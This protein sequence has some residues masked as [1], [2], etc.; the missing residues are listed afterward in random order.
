MTA[1]GPEPPS[2]PESG[3][4]HQLVRPFHHLS[5]CAQE[6]SENG[7]SIRQYVTLRKLPASLRP[8][9][10]EELEAKHAADPKALMTLFYAT[11][12]GPWPDL[13]ASLLSRVRASYP[14]DPRVLLGSFAL[15]AVRRDWRAL[16]EALDALDPTAL[17]SFGAFDL[18]HHH[19]LRATAHAALGYLDEARR[20]LALAEAIPGGGC[21]EPLKPLRAALDALVD[22]ITPDD[23]ARD[24]PGVRQSLA[25]LQAADARLALGDAAGAIAL[26]ERPLIWDLAEAQS[27]ARLAAAYLELSCVTPGERLRKALALATFLD[28]AGNP[29]GDDRR[30][31]LAPGMLYAEARIDALRRAALVWMEA[32]QGVERAPLWRKA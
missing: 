3:P 18:K 26:L 8:A 7:E 32:D 23:L 19:H 27:L 15:P 13:A 17:A 28:C 12:T 20:A 25:V 6:V 2:L 10:V 31:A 30:E 14:E 16:G 1:L 29:L 21:A 9:A 5:W 4:L 11:I 24:R 22:P